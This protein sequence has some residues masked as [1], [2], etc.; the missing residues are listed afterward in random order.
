MSILTA[1]NFKYQGRKPLDSRIVQSTIAD[2]TA[3]AESIIYNGIIVYVESEKKFYTFDVNNTIDPTLKKWRELSTGGSGNAK[4]NRYTQDTDYKTDEIIIY[5]DKIYLVLADFKSD[6]TQTSIVDSFEL[7]LQ[8]NKFVPLDEDTNC[9]EYKQ[10]TPYK[11][12][13]LVYLGKELK[14]VV[15]DYTSDSTQVLVEDSFKA[16]LNNSSLEDI[17]EDIDIPIC[18][19]SCKTDTPADLPTSAIK[20][21][22]VLI[23]N[24]T[25]TAPNQA[26]IGVYDGTNWTIM[27]IPSG[28]FTFP[29]PTADGKLY[30]RKVDIGST[31]G[32]WE[33]FTEV[34]GNEVQITIKEMSDTADGLK[35]PAKGE[36]V[37]DNVRKIIVMGDG[38]TNLGSLKAFY[39]KTLTKA[40]IITLLGYTPED[41][42]NKG[43]PNGYAPL[44]ANA[45]VPIA[46][47]PDV[48]TDTYTK[49]EIDNKDQA[50]TTAM[51]T[52]INTETSRAKGVEQ[53]LRT[54]LDNHINDNVKHVTQTE[55]DAWNDKLEES[56]ITDLRNHITD[57]VI[58]VTQADKDKWNGMTTVYYVT[59]VADL[60]TTEVVTGNMGYVQV[61]A[62]GV[63]PVVCDQYIYDG[64]AWQPYD[65]GQISL[66]F[67]WGNIIGKPSST[68]IAIDNAVTVAHSHNNKL[69]LDKI[70]QSASG[71]FMYDGVE[72]GTKAIFIDNEN[73]LPTT[74]ENNTLYVIYEDSRVRNY[75]SISVWR[76]N[77]YQ[78]LGRGTQDSAPAVGDMSILQSEYYSVVANTTKKISITQ[79]QYFAFMPVEILKEIEGA[80]N[81]DRAILDFNGS[82]D[83]TNVVM[84]ASWFDYNNKLV[85]MNKFDSL[86]ENV[87]S[88]ETTLN[89][90]SDYYYS[91][92]DVDLSYYKD[93]DGI[94]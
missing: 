44:D 12:D 61:S 29:E 77:A 18:L 57:T 70:S 17:I 37:Y 67:N 75:P 3:M 43:Q 76:D 86:M 80:K 46:N 81:Q 71:N 73:L 55:K 68:P 39:E 78:I 48:L 19:G 38:T 45:K 88:L 49:S 28:K 13:E 63:T 4:I 20:G 24:C 1:D 23:E 8:N 66:S 85:S 93:I 7:D 10:N 84:D 51:T 94:N 91:D 47:L 90:V 35:V 9:V 27:P 34:D 92:V 22:W 89:T 64:T 15:A 26:G 53:G 62:A 42:A 74:G 65:A 82:M 5:D 32:Q 16:D 50:V 31:T 52:L 83:G 41:S 21:N 56:D 79:N 58:H 30:F 60:P 36:L 40:D 69:V 2:M 14:R 11:K 54:D 25:T 59:N 72:I 87:K 33:A 6:N